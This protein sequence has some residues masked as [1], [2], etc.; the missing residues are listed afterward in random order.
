MA[1]T[2]DSPPKMETA[3]ESQPQ[4]TTT[5]DALAVLHGIHSLLEKIDTRLEDHGKRLLEIERER[6]SAIMTSS[7]A[8]MH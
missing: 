4:I 8:Q 1:T 7:K 3:A 5:A 6:L 2:D